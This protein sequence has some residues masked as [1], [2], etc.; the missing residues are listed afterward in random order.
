MPGVIASEIVIEL[1]FPVLVT[2]VPEFFRNQTM[3]ER[4]LTQD[5]K[6]EAASVPGNKLRRIAVDAVEESADQLR[7]R[8]GRFTERPNPKR[9]AL[10]HRARDRDHPVQI[11]RQK[12]A[13]RG[14]SP[15]LQRPGDHV[16][17]G[18]R[19]RQ[20]MQAAQPIDIGDRLDIENERRVHDGRC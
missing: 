16:G 15:L 6:I 11:Q 9:I 3:D 18:K 8:V 4:P 13:A 19:R 2:P 7:L 20:V 12:I 14:C 17:I 5:R 10:A 1:E